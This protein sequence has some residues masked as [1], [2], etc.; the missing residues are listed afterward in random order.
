MMHLIPSDVQWQH[1]A[2][3]L[4]R[5]CAGSVVGVATPPGGA[6]DTPLGSIAFLCIVV[7]VF[8]DPLF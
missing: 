2:A 5:F 3:T 4:L 8:F 7:V 6:T 1:P